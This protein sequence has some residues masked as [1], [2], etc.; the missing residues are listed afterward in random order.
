[1]YPLHFATECNS[2]DVKG[3]VK[4]KLRQTIFLPLL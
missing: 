2:S 4:N 1:M 3:E